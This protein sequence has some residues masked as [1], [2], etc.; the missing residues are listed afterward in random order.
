MHLWLIVVTN[1]YVQCCSKARDYKSLTFPFLGRIHQNVGR[2]NWKLRN[3]LQ[4]K[5][6]KNKQNWCFPICT[7]CRSR[8]TFVLFCWIISY[9]GK[10][11]IKMP[12]FVHLWD[13][14][15]ALNFFI[16]M[17]TV[18]YLGTVHNHFCGTTPVLDFGDTWSATFHWIVTNL[19]INSD[20]FMVTLIVAS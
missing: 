8:C 4:K 14:K 7:L 18:P 3:F 1:I 6:K 2:I 5:N 17:L 13:F 10:W 15:R 12:W 19:C 20:Y 16:A 9:F 11:S